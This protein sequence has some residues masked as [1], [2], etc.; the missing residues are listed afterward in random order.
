MP[1]HTAD[2]YPTSSPHDSSK[3][4]IGPATVAMIAVTDAKARA[5][6]Q[7]GPLSLATSAPILVTSAAEIR[8]KFGLDPRAES[9]S[10]HPVKAARTLQ[11]GLAQAQVGGDIAN[12]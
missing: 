2:A 8:F 12:R 4:G 3:N 10:G 9:Y 7:T 5:K 1:G 11:V 6:T